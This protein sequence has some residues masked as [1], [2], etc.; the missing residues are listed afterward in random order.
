MPPAP[1]RQAHRAAR[2]QSAVHPAEQETAAA[3]AAAAGQRSR[4]SAEPAE[5]VRAVL[6]WAGTFTPP[7]SQHRSNTV[8]I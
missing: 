2:G 5:R 4:F 1:H 6:P 7:V 8:S 3:T